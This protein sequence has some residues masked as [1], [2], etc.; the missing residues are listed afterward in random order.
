MTR[1]QCAVLMFCSLVAPLASGCGKTS[2]PTTGPAGAP[3]TI[4]KAAETAPLF[5]SVIS[6][7]DSNPQAVDMAMKLAGFALAEKRSVFVFFNVKGVNV[8]VTAL[9]DDAQFG[10]GPP[11]KEQLAG[12]IE[13]G[14]EI[15]ACPICMKA[16]GVTADNLL[17]G[18]SVTNREALFSKIGPDTCVFTY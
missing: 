4:V 5:L 1:P 18:V 16:L 12:L 8:P 9:P 11:F 14:A 13:Q 10:A 2:D 6:D 17:E 15:H 3:V 7:L